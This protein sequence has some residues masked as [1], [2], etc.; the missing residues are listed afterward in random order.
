MNR[1]NIL[2]VFKV[3]LFRL[4][5]SIYEYETNGTTNERHMN[6]KLLY[7]VVRLNYHT[8]GYRKCSETYIS[9][10]NKNNIMAAHDDDKTSV[11]IVWKRR[12]MNEA[13]LCFAQCFYCLVTS[14]SVP[15]HILS[16]FDVF[17]FG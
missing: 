5:L 17:L 4:Y 8:S 2:R 14:I 13:A 11:I 16:H 1:V 9:Y 6:N 12:R 7:G 15:S 10:G 3:L